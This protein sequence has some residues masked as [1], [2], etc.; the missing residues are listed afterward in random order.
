MTTDPLPSHS[1]VR[2]AVLLWMLCLAN[3][4]GLC[5]AYTWRNVAIGG[6]G[7]VTGVV[8]HPSEPNLRYARTDVGG[9]YRWSPASGWMP[10]ND[11]IGGLDNEFM[12][13]GVLSL[14]LDPADPD[15]VYLACG[16]Y[17]ASWA[18]FACVLRS[19]NRGA[20]W[21]RVALPFKLAGNGEGRGTG[22]RLSVD[23]QD[24][25]Q[26]LLGTSADGLWRSPDRGATWTRITAFTPTS[27]TFVLHDPRKAGVIYVG[28]ADSVGPT[29][30]RS[31]DAGIS[32][33]YV[34]G[35]T[36]GLMALQGKLDSAG[37]LLLTYADG[38][39]PNGVSTGAVRK[40]ANAATTTS[41]ADWTD[42]TPSHGQGGYCGL[43]LDVRRP[44]LIVVST[45]DRWWPQDEILL[46]ID[47]GATWKGVLEGAT[48]D[49]SM[50]TWASSLTSHWITDVEIDPFDS[51]RAT[52]VT[53][54]GLFSTTNLHVATGK[55]TWVFAN[56]GLEEAVPT[57]LVSPAEG[58]PLVSTI[59][60]FDGFRHDNLATAP[61]SRLA[62]HHGSNHS[63]DAAGAAPAVLVRLHGGGSVSRPPR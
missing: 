36:A 34:P 31:T 57:G 17:L 62:P 42:I 38:P 28:A 40:L 14:A 59:G 20:T 24:G 29:L 47:H 1:R 7:Y 46:S 43:A 32:W 22:E 30:W 13:L 50:G 8:Y 15:R 63:L 11:N 56:S 9:A 2:C 25:S 39:G 35:Q 55:P 49:F 19:T 10:L 54:F 41:A 60:D 53:G 21:T 26:L 18:P 33:A 6:G 44:G 52:F 45:L 58:P 5:A 37:T 61:S 16:Q 4:T 12:T 48:L 51:D 23:P 27:T 3:V